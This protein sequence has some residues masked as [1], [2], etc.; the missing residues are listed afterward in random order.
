MSATPEAV[1]AWLEALG[2]AP[3]RRGP[4]ELTVRVPSDKR[5]AVAVGVR[6]AERTLGAHAFVM[7][8]PDRNH[9]AV[10]RRLL[11]KNVGSHSWRF[12]IDDSGDVFLTAELPLGALDA[13]ALDRLLGALATLVDE[14]YEGLVRTG[15]D[16][17]SGTEFRPPPGEPG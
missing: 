8:G 4:R 17:P 10:Y 14:T 1:A 9:E 6:V 15:F 3:E 5:G 7:R 12:A 11:H 2:A 16:V 13:E